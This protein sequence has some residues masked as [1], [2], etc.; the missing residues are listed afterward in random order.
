MMPVTLPAVVAPIALLVALYS[1]C[2]KLHLALIQ[3]AGS[4]AGWTPTGWRRVGG[5]AEAGVGREAGPG[6]GRPGPGSVGVPQ[7]REGPH[8]GPVGLGGRSLLGRHEAGQ[9]GARRL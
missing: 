8:D 1:K 4:S 5:L 2:N 6:L 9:G 3:R 7:H